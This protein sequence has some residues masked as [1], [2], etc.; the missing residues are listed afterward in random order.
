MKVR[1]EKI[2][3]GESQKGARKVRK[4]AKNCV[5]QCFVVLEGQKSRLAKAA[6]AEPSWQMKHEKVLSRHCGAKHILK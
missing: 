5:F 3:K 2:R 4:V 6:G 1:S